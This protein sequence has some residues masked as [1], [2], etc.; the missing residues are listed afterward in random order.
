[1]FLLAAA[2]RHAH[3]VVNFPTRSCSTRSWVPTKI[4]HNPWKHN[5]LT[6]DAY[7]C[8]YAYIYIYMRMHIYI[9][10]CTYTSLSL[11]LST[12]YLFFYLLIHMRG[13]PGKAGPFSLALGSMWL[14]LPK[15]LQFLQSLQLSKMGLK[16]PRQTQIHIHIYIYTSTYVYMYS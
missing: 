11:Y 9:Y 15:A 3:S 2:K 10:K 4:A 8:V 16:H 1:M 6:A 5:T 7:I 14:S 13:A 12:V